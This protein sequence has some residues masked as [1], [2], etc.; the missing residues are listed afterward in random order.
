MLIVASCSREQ[1]HETKERAQN[2]AQKVSGTFDASTPLGTKEPSPTPQ[3]I[4]QQRFDQQWRQLQSFRAQEE[5]RVAAAQMQA[6]AQQ[7]ALNLNI[8]HGKKESFKGLDANAINS[9][10]RRGS[11]VSRPMESL[12]ISNCPA[13]TV[14]RK[15][16]IAQKTIHEIGKSPKAAP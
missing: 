12:I 4:E 15:S 8:V 14:T 5:A 9:A 10:W 7:K 16:M 6:A 3:E 2:A 13:S 11:G 1:A